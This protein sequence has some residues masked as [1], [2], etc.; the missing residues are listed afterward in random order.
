M[1]APIAKKVPH[2][3]L[4]HGDSFTDNYEWLRDK[5]NPEVIAYLEAENA[6]TETFTDPL[7]SLREDIFEE[8]K[9][10]TQET[11]L[12]VPT[13]RGQWWYYSR[14]FE[15]KQYGVHCRCPIA[16]KEDWT[17]PE[18]TV[19]AII[20]GEQVLLDSN[21]EAQGYDFFAL[22]AFSVSNDGNLLAYSVDLVGDE[23]FTLRIKDLQTGILLPDNIPGISH[24]ATWSG[25]GGY[26]FY[27]T[28]DESWR[29]DTV[30][31]HPVGSTDNSL[32]VAVFHEPD[33]RF[34]V[35]FGTSRSEKY[36]MIWI[37]SKI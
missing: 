27:Q 1:T 5:E 23:R 21:S 35:S 37:G 11:D 34:W 2:V 6:Y 20:P 36:L 8:I 10:R 16:D 29:P 18:L 26:I 19:D 33:E 7:K 4:H 32:D 28:V 30:W 25:D 31:R 12:S 15:G 22:G 3:R 14:S 24:G 9:A 17:P 13:R